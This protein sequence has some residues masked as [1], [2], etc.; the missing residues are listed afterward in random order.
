MQTVK[1]KI[2]IR[3]LN[4]GY[5]NQFI[6]N[7]L[8]GNF[9]Y[10]LRK[11]SCVS[12]KYNCENCKVRF[13]CIYFRT[14]EPK[15]DEN[16]IYYGKVEDIPRPYIISFDE[17]QSSLNVIKDSLYSFNLILVNDFI[18]NFVFFLYAFNNIGE[19]GLANRKIKYKIESVEVVSLNNEIQ[20]IFNGE[21]LQS[22]SSNYIIDLKKI[23]TY[24]NDKYSN[25]KFEKIIVKYI[26]PF[27]VKHHGKF[28][29][30][31]TFE[32][33][34]KSVLRRTSLFLK[35]YNGNEGFFFDI[36][37]IN[38]FF[39]NVESKI[40][41]LQWS[42]LKRYS[43]RKKT[44]IPFGG[45][46]GTAE[47]ILNGFNLQKILPYIILCKYLHIGKN[48]VFGNGCYSFILK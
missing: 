43:S 21:E 31:I 1:F 12:K 37:E 27:R 18:K 38:D 6:G 24:I 15:I 3:F 17:Y 32:I 33:F 13:K 35:Y 46:I 10:F 7:I 8:R 19:I 4:A 48:S 45:V 9:G 44:K 36:R 40:S 29:D 30:N 16:H 47:Y 22:Y 42:D 2:N 23:N 25:K 5:I 39:D 26:T 14:F 28:T 41:D 20:Q 34:V 11:I